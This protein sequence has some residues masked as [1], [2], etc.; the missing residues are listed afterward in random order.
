M[1]F[2]VGDKNLKKE[3]FVNLLSEIPLNVWEEIVKNE[4]E[5]RLME[6]FYDKF[7]FGPL[8]VLMVA[9]GL[10]DYQLKGDAE[11]YWC[12]IQKN[13][14][15]L[16]NNTS[17]D[18]IRKSL[19]NFYDNER[20]QNRKRERLKSFLDSKLASEELWNSSPEEVSRKFQDIWVELANAMKQNK[21]DKTIVFAMKS[22]GILLLMAKEKQ[23]VQLPDFPKIEIPV[24]SRIRKFTEKLSGPDLK[25]G[26]YEE[27]QDF[28]SEVLNQ[29]NE[30]YRSKGVWKNITMIHLDSLIWQITPSIEQGCQEVCIEYFT[31]LRITEIGKKLCALMSDPNK[32]S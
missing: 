19:S 17:I 32:T 5:W 1:V 7:D 20:L 25:S 22:L 2:M 31:N 3:R 21:K 12:S 4:P 8:S 16:N 29:L 27:I 24:D 15:G 9:T 30:K 13:L 23:N 26:K 10:N 6:Q 18:E 14:K 11:I 28:W